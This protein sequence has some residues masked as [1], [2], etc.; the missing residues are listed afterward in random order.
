[1]PAS[2]VGEWGTGEGADVV[3]DVS[4]AR[5]ILPDGG[6]PSVYVQVRHAGTAAASG[7]R[8]SGTLPPELQ[9]TGSMTT[10]QWDCW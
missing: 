3:V 2:V 9:E 10:N 1:M 5:H 8:F 7:V 6:W 4:A